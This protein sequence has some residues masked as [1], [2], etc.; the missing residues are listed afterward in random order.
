MFTIP[1]PVQIILDELGWFCGSDDRP[2]GGASRTAM[3]RCHVAEDYEVVNY[4]G[5][6]V[7]MKINCA[8]ILGEW[9]PDNRLRAIPH[10]SRFG[11]KWDNASHLDMERAKRCAQVINN[12]PYIDFCLHGLNHGYYMDGVDNW[13]TSDYF[14]A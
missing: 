10:L 3:P 4:I 12:S 14:Y 5:E 2:I 6:Q 8:F 11:D 9:D 7:G 13:D 1:N